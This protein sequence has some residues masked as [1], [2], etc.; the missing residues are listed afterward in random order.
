MHNISQVFVIDEQLSFSAVCV[1]AVPNY[2]IADMGQRKQNNSR[3]KKGEGTIGAPKDNKVRDTERGVWMNV[4]QYSTLRTVHGL[5]IM[6][7]AL[8]LS[9]SLLCHYA[10]WLHIGFIRFN[11]PPP[12]F[13]PWQ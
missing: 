6:S 2:L 3:G 8:R 1:D 13:H 12:P 9:S 5:L 7:A 10:T 11:Q 4:N